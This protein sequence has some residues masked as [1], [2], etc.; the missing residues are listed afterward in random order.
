MIPSGYSFNLDGVAL[1]LPLSVLFIAQVYGVPAERRGSSSSLMAVMLFT[2]KGAAGVTGGAF[3]ALAATV[4]AAGLPVEGLAL[5]LGVDRFM[6]LGRAVV[7]TLGN[8]VAA[9]VVVASWDGDFDRN[10]WAHADEERRALSQ[11]IVSPVGS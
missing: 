2:C 10:A 9:V 3:A 7:N 5:L 6:S 1:T 8:A 11:E 4:V